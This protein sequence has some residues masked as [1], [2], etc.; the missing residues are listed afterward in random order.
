MFLAGIHVLS[1]CPI[2]VRSVSR[3]EISSRSNESRRTF[4]HDRPLETRHDSDRVEQLRSFWPNGHLDRIYT[5]TLPGSIGARGRGGLE[6][7][8]RQNIYRAILPGLNL[9]CRIV[10]TSLADFRQF[11]TLFIQ[12]YYVITHQSSCIPWHSL[13]SFLVIYNV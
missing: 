9:K 6:R 7:F 5:V 11:S 10:H 1:G 4:G 12:E 8:E 3:N 13:V 2:E